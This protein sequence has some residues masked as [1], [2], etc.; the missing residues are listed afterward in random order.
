M[1]S[2]ETTVTA[3]ATVARSTATAT[4]RK[5]KLFATILRIKK[6]CEDSRNGDIICQFSLERLKALILVLQQPKSRSIYPVTLESLNKL[7]HQMNSIAKLNPIFYLAEAIHLH[8]EVFECWN[9]LSQNMLPLAEAIKKVPPEQQES[10]RPLRQA[11]ATYFDIS[12]K[13]DSGLSQFQQAVRDEQERL[14]SATDFG[15]AIA[16]VLGEENSLS[17]KEWQDA[18]RMLQQQVEI[19][20]NQ[21]STANYTGDP[22]ARS[23]A[24]RHQE[25]L[26]TLVEQVTKAMPPMEE[27]IFPSWALDPVS[28]KVMTE[29]VN[30][31]ATCNHT[32][33]K[34]TFEKWL[35][36]GNKTCPVCG[37]TL[38]ALYATPDKGLLQKIRAFSSGESIE[39]SLNESLSSLNSDWRNLLEIAEGRRGSIYLR[40]EADEQTMNIGTTHSKQQQAK[41]SSLDANS[42]HSK[43][44][45]SSSKGPSVGL[46][47]DSYHSKHDSQST[48]RTSTGTI[49]GLESK[50]D[51]SRGAKGY[52]AH[53]FQS[54]N[55]NVSP[56]RQSGRSKTDPLGGGSSHSRAKGGDPLGGGSA[57]SSRTSSSKSAVKSVIT[58]TG[59]NN[60]DGGGDPLG[61]GSTHRRTSMVKSLSTTMGKIL[62]NKPDQKIVRSASAKHLTS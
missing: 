34:S 5:E 27:P 32:M 42:Y 25:F 36:L 48:K 57:H 45:S 41:Y 6:I 55:N 33:N 61:G 49:S 10:L 24:L 1:A 31:R 43:R 4:I 3:T 51:H 46:D 30:V 16:A 14:A 22:M 50:S 21:L 54:N 9:F 23:K 58:F 53:M 11:L 12:E 60:R 47:S 20:T 40:E 17:N 18:L 38:K 44:D 39:D 59:G 28:Q 2:T 29:P 19:V 26:N 7:K 35:E 56:K 8:V 37:A 15:I 13:Q 62:K 52:A